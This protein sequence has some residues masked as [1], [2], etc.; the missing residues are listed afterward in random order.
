MACHP[1]KGRRTGPR[2]G[3]RHGRMMTAWDLAVEAWR[4]QAEADSR[5]YRTELDEYR[6]DHPMPQLGDFMEGDF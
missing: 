3:C 2:C 5:G 6:R 4:D 1:W